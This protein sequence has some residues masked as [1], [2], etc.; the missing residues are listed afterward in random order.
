MTAKASTVTSVAWNGVLLDPDRVRAGGQVDQP[1]L[2]GSWKG[3]KL[4][5][6][7][8]VDPDAT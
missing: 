2:Y 4:D 8:A 6:R 5:D 7:R 1:V 3:V